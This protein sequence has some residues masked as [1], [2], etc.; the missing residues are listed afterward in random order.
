M[1]NLGFCSNRFHNFIVETPIN[2][3]KLGRTI[4]RISPIAK[5]YILKTNY[6]KAAIFKKKS[7]LKEQLITSKG[8]I[9]QL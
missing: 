2:F 5:K 3:R 6:L 9:H 1:V 8:T 4:D 7:L